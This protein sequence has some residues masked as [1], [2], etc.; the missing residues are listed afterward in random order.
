MGFN[1]GWTQGHATRPSVLFDSLDPRVDHVVDEPK[2]G[3]D[4]A[5]HRAELSQEVAQ[6]LGW[7]QKQIRDG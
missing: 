3:E 5:N 6:P 7:L 4:A 1:P 2:D